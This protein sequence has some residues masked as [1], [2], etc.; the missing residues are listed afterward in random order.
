MMVE[1]Q[2]VVVDVEEVKHVLE[3]PA[4]RKAATV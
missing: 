3:E 4:M 2:R 1:G